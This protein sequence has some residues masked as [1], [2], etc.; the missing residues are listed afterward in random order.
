MSPLL[1]PTLLALCLGLSLSQSLHAEETPAAE[2]PTSDSAAPKGGE[3]ADDKDADKATEVPRVP[4]DER[5]SAEADALERQLPQAEQQQ[6]Q[7]GDEHF[8]ALWKPANAA[9]A[10][11]VVILLPGAEE[12]ADWPTVIGPLRNKLTDAGWSTL[13]LTL[14]DSPDAPLPAAILPQ[15][16][17]VAPP[18]DA[19]AEP[20]QE[21]DATSEDKPAEDATA[22]PAAEPAPA[23]PPVDPAIRVF[24]RIQA[25]IAYAEQQG[26][27]SIVLLGHGDGAYWAGLFLAEKKPPQVENL[28]TVAAHLPAGQHPALEELIPGLKLATG[29]FFYKDQAV[30]RSDAVKRQQA[31]KRLAHPNYVQVALKALPGNNEA[32]Q[33]QLYRRIRGW[34]DKQ[35]PAKK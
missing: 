1:R 29:D 33:E 34:L 35:L 3:N 8:L 20:N 6:L 24:A 18:V 15:P 2:Q 14:P 17:V 22:A 28:L 12:T 30:D 5:T 32:E 16:I 13:S 11:G 21:K 19:S 27:Q 25:G 23:A 4:L 31:S 9:E 7:A 26:A 10:T